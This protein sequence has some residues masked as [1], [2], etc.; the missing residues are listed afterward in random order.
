MTLPLWGQLEKAQDDPQTIEEA[1]AQ[2]ISEHEADPEAHLGSGESLEAHKTE[3]I[4]DHPA[5][6]IAVDKL[7]RGLLLQTSF[8]SIDGWADYTGGTGQLIQDFGSV[9]LRTG[10]TNNSYA[11]IAAVPSGVLNFDASKNLFWRATLRLAQVTN[12][13]MAFGVGYLVDLADYNGF[14]FRISNGSLYA[15]MGDYDNLVE[16]AIAGVTLTDLHTYE[17]RY[18]ASAPLVEFFIDGTLVAS[19]DSGD[20]PIDDDGCGAFM[21]KNTAGED[22]FAYVI[23]FMYQQVD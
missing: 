15:Y 7:P 17:I 1:I 8:E 5:G 22:K 4:I 14:G 23:N 10:A 19:F 3:G 16:E 13:T 12:Q 2:A 11:G 6:S 18:D 9:T 20:F 21:L